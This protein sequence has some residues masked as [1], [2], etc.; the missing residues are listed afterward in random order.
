MTQTATIGHNNPP[1]PIDE[2]S[3]QFEDVRAEAENWT[4]GSPVEN[5]GQMHAVDAMRADLRKWRLA[6]EK[7]QKDATAPL[8]AVY[9]AELDRWKPTIEDAKRIEGCLVAALD[10][11][12]RK[13]AAQRAEAE[14]K[15]REEAEAAAE[16]LRKAHAEADKAN[17]EQQRAL[18]E[19]E[20]E[21]EIARIKAAQA[22]KSAT[23]KGMVTRTFYE[24]TDAVALLRWIWA[25]DRKAVEA[26]AEEYAR[27][28]HAQGTPMD[29]VKVWQEKVAK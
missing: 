22:K 15:A 9:Q 19:A 14:R 1:D 21:A 10:G 20:R 11:F 27:R 4:D 23:V 26:F 29:G 25:H 13:L 16:A 2:I 8:R 5:E 3:A 24:V 17:L 7:G 18:A 6:L 28:N 12:K